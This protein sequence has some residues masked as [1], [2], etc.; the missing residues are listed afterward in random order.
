[1]LRGY[2]LNASPEIVLPSTPITLCKTG[3]ITLVVIG[4]AL[5]NQSAKTLSAVVFGAQNAIFALN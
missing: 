1:M 3:I 4:R 5:H 2:H